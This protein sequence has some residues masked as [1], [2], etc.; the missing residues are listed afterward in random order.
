[1]N[2]LLLTTWIAAAAA[3]DSAEPVLAVPVG[4]PMPAPAP[5]APPQATQPLA[6]PGNTPGAAPP[7]SGLSSSERLQAL[8][9]YKR[10]RLSIN[11]EIEVSGGG[12]RVYTGFGWAGPGWGGGMVITDPVTTTRTWGTYQ[13]AQRLDVPT[14]LLEANAVGAS[15]ELTAD[16]TGAQQRSRVWYS[17]AGVGVAGLL[18]GTI[19]ARTAPTEE[20]FYQYSSLMTPS[21]GLALGGM[22]AGSFPAAR[23]ERLRRYPSESIGIQEAQA[24][25]D[26]HNDALRASLG[27]SP[28]DVWVIESADEP[29]R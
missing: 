29:S 21:I 7:A 6:I 24:L 2:T 8:R 1:M 26:A 17:V 22:L 16:I 10:E 4:A 3:Q 15:G 28:E 13:G 25:A 19:G 5:A 27:L 11:P 20:L 18:V 14:F 12:T 9:Q 23:A